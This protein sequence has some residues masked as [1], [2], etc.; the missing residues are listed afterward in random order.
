MA[1]TKAVCLVH[2]QPLYLRVNKETNEVAL[3]CLCCDIDRAERGEAL[4]N[5]RYP[6]QLGALPGND[7]DCTEVSR[8]ARGW[9][10]DARS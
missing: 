3:A 7:S 1:D 10:D 6:P 9:T 4:I 2:K 5:S 8:P